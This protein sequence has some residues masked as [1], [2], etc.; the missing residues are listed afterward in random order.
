[1]K[2]VVFE[3]IKTPKGHYIYDR[4]VNTI[5]S[6]S[7][8]EYEEFKRLKQ[9]DNE[10]EQSPIV[11][12]YRRKGL[13][14]ENNVSIIRHPSTELL[15]HYCENRLNYMILQVTQQCNL[16]C[17]YCAYSGLYYNRQ[18]NS[19]RMS[20]ETAKK[21][22]DFFIQRTA[23]SHYLRLG[24]YGGEPLLEFDLIKKCVA[25]IKD[26]VEGRDV[27]FVTTTNGTLLTDEKIKFLAENNFHL[28]ISL[29]GSKA[30]HDACRVFP[31]GQGSFDIIMKNLRR[32]REL[33][34]D[35]AKTINISIR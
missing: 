1:M 18:H 2:R 9:D 11:Q 7:P 3:P 15:P 22:I 5:F 4:S 17:S 13:L 16:R 6:V 30:E 35:Y 31:N 23:E 28:M 27:T 8:D 14:R 26:K 25:Y 10:I 21:A 12:Y 20:F 33:Y 32:V 29:D 34:P 19:Q 24:F